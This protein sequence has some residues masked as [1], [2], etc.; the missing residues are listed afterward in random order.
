MLPNN[1]SK[2]LPNCKRVLNKIQNMKSVCNHVEPF[3]K[4]F[5]RAKKKAFE[6]YKKV[7]PIE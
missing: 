5:I 1:N 6:R 3:S 4:E 2:S 7:Y